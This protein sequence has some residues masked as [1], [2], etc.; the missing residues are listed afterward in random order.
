[1]YKIVC[2]TVADFQLIASWLLTWDVPFKVAQG[3]NIE[4]RFDNRHLPSTRIAV[5]INTKVYFL[6]YG[7][8][9]KKPIVSNITST[10]VNPAAVME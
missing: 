2:F 5:L 9:S 6:L 8:H 4:I 1:M 10:L 3:V 7:E